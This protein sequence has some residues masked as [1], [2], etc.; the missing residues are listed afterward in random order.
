M[1]FRFNSM[2]MSAFCFFSLV[3]RYFMATKRTKGFMNSKNFRPPGDWNSDAVIDGRS[4]SFETSPKINQFLSIFC[5][6]ELCKVIRYSDKYT[7]FQNPTNTCIP[8]I[9][10][11]SKLRLY[12]LVK[13]GVAIPK[14][15]SSS[16]FIKNSK[17]K[18]HNLK[19]EIASYF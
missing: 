4:L 5:Y 9:R 7:W 15:S 17:K 6:F 14:V 19:N 12:F 10:F 2:M 8:S 1:L 11:L 3:F 13:N 16:F 18:V